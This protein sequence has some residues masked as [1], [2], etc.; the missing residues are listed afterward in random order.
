MTCQVWVK[1]SHIGK[2]TCK[3]NGFVRLDADGSWR[4]YLRLCR[5]P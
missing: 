2:G 5:V 1:D 4:F 3:G